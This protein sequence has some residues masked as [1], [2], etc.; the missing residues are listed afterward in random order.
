MKIEES[1]T[2]ERGTNDVDRVTIQRCPSC[3]AALKFEFTYS[4][5]SLDAIVTCW[6][7]ECLWHTV[8]TAS[9]AAVTM[10]GLDEF[11]GESSSQGWVAD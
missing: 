6:S 7:S 11:P 1:W 10:Y 9:D 4:S 8:L 5:G 3:A 2:W